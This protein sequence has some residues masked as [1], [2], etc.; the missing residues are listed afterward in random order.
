MT[1]K[2]FKKQTSLA[3]FVTSMLKEQCREDFA[4]LG[5]SVLESLLLGLNHKQNASN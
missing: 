4:V 3:F 2:A 5:Y 1:E